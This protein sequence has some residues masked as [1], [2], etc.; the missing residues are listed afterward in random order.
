MEGWIKLYRNM[1]TNKIVMHDPETFMLWTCLLLLAAHKDYQTNYG[2]QVITLKSGQLI[3]GRKKLAEL[4]GI[5]EYK[6]YRTLRMLESAQQIAQQKSACGTVISIL[7][8]D[9]YQENAQPN[10]QRMHNKCTLYN[11]DKN[12]KKR[13]Y[14]PKEEIRPRH[15]PKFE[16]EEEIESCEMP[17]DMRERFQFLKEV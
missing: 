13:G 1:L 4:T 11:N 7:Q 14:T 12:E 17:E 8:W 2:G 9:V 10:A 6:I 16:P 5:S 15:Y 3:T